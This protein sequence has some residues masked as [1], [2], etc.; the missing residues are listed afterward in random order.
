M[1]KQLMFYENAVPVT[2]ERHGDLAIAFT[3]NY[4]FARHTNSLPL[5]AIEIP[6]A[7]QEY[8]IV[9]A[10]EG[11]QLLPTVVLGLEPEENAYVG[12][13][14]RWAAKYV[15]AFVRRYPFVFSSLNEGKSL[16]LC[17]D[18]AF[19]GCNRE[20]RGQRL[21]TDAGE[22]T[23]YLENMLK[24]LKEFQR[25]HKRTQAFCQQL[26]ELDLLET[27][28]AKVKTSTG[29]QVTLGGFRAVSRE[30]LHALPPEKLAEL[31]K[32]GALELIYLHL[33]SLQNLSGMLDRLVMSRRMAKVEAEKNKPTIN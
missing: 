10:G 11:E 7:A 13:K 3:G 26:V 18:E 14:G 8:A 30:K 28:S 27:R 25:S 33:Y 32:S 21:F 1:T 15:P 22:R 17:V 19:S 2:K 16:A 9:F 5:M 20:G 29:Q 12:P 23:E 24:F 31:A 4:G 6:A